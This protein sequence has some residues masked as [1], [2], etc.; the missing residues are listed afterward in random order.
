M[1]PK[2]KPQTV[3][4]KTAIDSNAPESAG[5]RG[6]CGDVTGRTWFPFGC[7]IF[8][9]APLCG[10]LGGE[11]SLTEPTMSLSLPG[12]HPDLANSV[13]TSPMPTMIPAP[14]R[15]VTAECGRLLVDDGK[16]GTWPYGTGT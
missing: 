15:M 9:V 4:I 7:T 14:M 3:E 13:T 10:F 16:F 12:H 6:V 2:P 11:S 1:L 8:V 5:E